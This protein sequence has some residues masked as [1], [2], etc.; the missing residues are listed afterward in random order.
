LAKELGSEKIIIEGDSLLTIQVVEAM[1]V[2]GVVGHIIKGI[3][4]GFSNFQEVN[5]RRIDRNNN[6][7]TH[8]L[9]QQAK[10]TRKKKSI[11]RSEI[12]DFC[13]TFLD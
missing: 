13:L 3:G 8:K 11:W 5:V 9:A 2:R 12:P 7:I 1:D 4:Q 10:K 6:K